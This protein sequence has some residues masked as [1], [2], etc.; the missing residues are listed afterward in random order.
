[1]HFLLLQDRTITI[2]DLEVVHR[3][4]ALVGSPVPLLLPTS[5][6]IPIGSSTSQ[7]SRI[8]K[9]SD[10]Y[11]SQ[12]LDTPIPMPTTVIP[13]KA[14]NSNYKKW[15]VQGCVLAK[16]PIH[17]YTNQCRLGKLFGFD[18]LDCC[19]EEIYVSAFNNFVDTFYSLVEI[20]T[21]YTISNGTIK[22]SSPSYNHLNNHLEIV[23][24]S[25]SAIH[26]CLSEFPSIPLHSFHF[27][28]INDL[29]I[30]PSNSIVD[31]I[32]LVSSVSP[33]STIRKKDD[34]ETSR[35][36]ICLRDTSCFS[37]DVT[38][39][40]HHCH[41][42]GSQL[43][44]LYSFEPPLVLAIKGGRLMDYS[45]KNV[46]GVPSSFVLINPDI[47]ATHLLQTWYTD[48]GFRA[49]SPS[50]NRKYIGS[51]SRTHPSK[52]IFALQ[53]MQP[54]GSLY[55]LPLL[56]LTWTNSTSLHALSLLM[57]FNA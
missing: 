13:F 10:V 9:E 51:M 53:S 44:S 27:K 48:Y 46:G 14:L 52:T 34:S 2:L 16:T 26:P 56:E 36:T 21:V 11:S 42:E 30:L 22:T 55:V 7:T 3:K 35:R 15:S 24:S 19:G 1:M 47:E 43:A 20:G 28:T 8:T 40:G 39:W 49:A 50:L 18:L 5:F 33:A 38:L 54:S 57:A 41:T 23:L 45:G 12:A 6:G 17:E 29:Q 4:L 37:I 25:T 31:L 32:G